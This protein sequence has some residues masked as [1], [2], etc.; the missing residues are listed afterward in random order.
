[1]LLKL[2]HCTLRRPKRSS[3][4]RPAAGPGATPFGLQ[5]GPILFLVWHPEVPLLPD[6]AGK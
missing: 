1:M 3:R 4:R 5:A 6:H 2:P